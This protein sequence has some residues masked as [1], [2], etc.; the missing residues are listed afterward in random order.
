MIPFLPY[1]VEL[2]IWACG[3][4]GGGGGRSSIATLDDLLQSRT[5]LITKSFLYDSD[6]EFSSVIDNSWHLLSI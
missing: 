2:G 1:E 3:N 4:T 6:S 5:D